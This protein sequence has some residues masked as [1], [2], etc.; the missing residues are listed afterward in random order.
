MK[1]FFSVIHLYS[2]SFLKFHTCTV[3][4]VQRIRSSRN[5]AVTRDI[6]TVFYPV[7]SC[8]WQSCTGSWLKCVRNDK[9]RGAYARASLPSSAKRG[10]TCIRGN[11]VCVSKG[12]LRYR[13]LV[14]E[15]WDFRE[16]VRQS[17][18]IHRRGGCTRWIP[19][20][21]LLPSRL[22][23]IIYNTTTGTVYLY[24]NNWDIK[25]MDPGR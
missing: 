23:Y 8:T 3:P 2:F 15:S 1:R 16:V 10:E 4:D 6:L 21:P 24:T 25:L 5:R 18:I 14:R 17:R 20:D 12:S 11:T 13:S 9:F 19:E 7:K 22:P